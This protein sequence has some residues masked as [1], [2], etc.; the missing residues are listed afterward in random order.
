MS[1]Q[2]QQQVQRSALLLDL[3]VLDLAEYRTDKRKFVRE[4]RDACRRVGFFLLKHGIPPAAAAAAISG[5]GADVDGDNNDDGDDNRDVRSV[6]RRQLDETRTFFE[7]H[8]LETKMAISYENSPSFRGYMPLG[9]ENTAGETDW[10][11]Q[12]EYAVE[13]SMKSSSCSRLCRSR[14]TSSNV[15]AEATPS[16]AQTT[17]CRCPRCW[18]PYE[19]LRSERNPW[20]A[21]D[22]QPTLRPA[23][24]LYVAE[25]L[26][27]A[28][29]LRK[30][31]CLALGLE[32]THLDPLFEKGHDNPPH[33]VLK[34]VSYPPVGSLR[35]RDDTIDNDGGD[36]DDIRFGV[37]EHTDT[38]FLTIIAHD[39]NDNDV[40]SLQVF[41]DG[42]WIDV[43]SKCGCDYLVVNLGEQAEIFSRGFFLATPHR[44]LANTT[45]STRGRISVPFFYN[46]ALSASIE[47]IS[48]AQEE[49]LLSLFDEG[50]DG[51]T[52]GAATAASRC[53]RRRWRSR[54]DR[55]LPTVG[56]NT[57]KS[58]ARSHP[59]VF[60]RHHPD[61]SFLEDGRVVS[62]T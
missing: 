60:E 42:R 28:D 54:Q 18:P 20:P 7:D 35:R 33:W 6:V 61:L 4:L 38:N 37:G 52:D 49:K 29:C 21:D 48:E 51:N 10:R 50:N 47:P 1:Q 22:V 25:M 57:F 39:D 15:G 26:R 23:T 44:V 2:Q 59:K 55:M 12:V 24:E 45:S 11:E 9:V 5:D 14:S 13:T 43:P 32:E 3:P 34:L 16:T 30:A 46:P 27:I 31:M 19:R 40:G 58:L 8:T 62:A 53:R 41:V 56:D 36:D 17:S